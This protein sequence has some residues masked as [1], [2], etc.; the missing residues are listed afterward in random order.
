ML[1]KKPLMLQAL[2]DDNNLVARVK[3]HLNQAQS[4]L[5]RV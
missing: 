1:T 2:Q 4:C 5:R 3:A